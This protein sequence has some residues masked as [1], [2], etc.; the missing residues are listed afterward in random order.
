MLSQTTPC[1]ILVPTQTAAMCVAAACCAK[2]TPQGGTVQSTG[3]CPNFCRAALHLEKVLHPCQYRADRG[4]GC[5]HSMTLCLILF[6]MVA[7]FLA[8]PPHSKKTTPR[9]DCVEIVRITASVKSSHPI[10]EW[11]FALPFCTVSEAF[12]RKTP[13]RAQDSRLPCFGATNPGMS[14]VSSLYTGRS[15][16]LQIITR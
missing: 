7:F 14:A 8:N 3:S 16:R 15:R 4:E 1:C 13:C 2:E 6:T 11:E 12:S 5:A 9:C 10:F